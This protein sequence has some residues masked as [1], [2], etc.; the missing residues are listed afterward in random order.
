[1]VQVVFCCRCA[2]LTPPS[3]LVSSPVLAASA[4]VAHTL[5]GPPHNS[6]WL[7][8]FFFVWN[9]FLHPPLPHTNWPSAC[10]FCT[11]WCAA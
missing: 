5:F 4:Q 11:W 7:S 10:S 3:A 1:M 9:F 2:P 6:R 8:S